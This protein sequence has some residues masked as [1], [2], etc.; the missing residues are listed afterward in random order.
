MNE[1][2]LPR[3]I[4]I[5]PNTHWTDE[6]NCA[7]SRRFGHVLVTEVSETGVT[8]QQETVLLYMTRK[9]FERWFRPVRCRC[10]DIGDG[11]CSVC[12]GCTACATQ[13]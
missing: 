12:T 5:N 3:Q 8:F 2:E 11:P 4:T 7:D 1:L 13:G 10:D 6:Y 9:D